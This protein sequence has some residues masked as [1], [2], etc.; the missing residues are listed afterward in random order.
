MGQ[1]ANKE[2]YEFLEHGQLRVQHDLVSGIPQFWPREVSLQTG[3]TDVEWREISEMGEIYAWT[4]S[5]YRP[6]NILVEA[7]YIVGL[8]QMEAG[9]RM[10]GR[11]VGI[12]PGNVKAGLKVRW[13]RE[14]S[15]NRSN[16]LVFEVIA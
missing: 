9:I 8:V 5:H 4:V 12:A 10:I 15:E 3:K 13:C 1:P 14:A 2:F 11:I 6:R 7:P 16:S